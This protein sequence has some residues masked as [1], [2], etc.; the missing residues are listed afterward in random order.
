[1]FY[2]KLVI[3]DRD[4]V[5]NY[6]SIEYIKTFEEWKSILGSLEVVVWFNQAGYCVVIAINQFGV[7][8]GLFDMVMLNA[9]YDKMYKAFVYVGGRIDAVFYCSYA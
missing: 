6:D 7:G 5:I 8:R 2:M 9:I 3:L 1:M 4:G